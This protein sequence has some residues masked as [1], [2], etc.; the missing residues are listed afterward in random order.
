MI[1]LRPPAIIFPVNPS[2]I[3]VLPLFKNYG[4]KYNVPI[5]RSELNT[6]PLTSKLYVYL[7][8]ELSE[9]NWYSWCFNGYLWHGYFNYW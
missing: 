5:L 3:K 2:K 8:K 1:E 7:H 6:T 9:K 4:D